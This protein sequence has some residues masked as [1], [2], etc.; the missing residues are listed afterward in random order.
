MW[1][2]KSIRNVAFLVHHFVV[3]II[4]ANNTQTIDYF[5][6][7]SVTR[8][9]IKDIKSPM[10]QTERKK[11]DQLVT[12]GLWLLFP[13]LEESFGLRRR[14]IMAV[15]TYRQKTVFFIFCKTLREEINDATDLSKPIWLNFYNIFTW[16]LNFKS[17]PSFID[18]WAFKFQGAAWE[19]QP[20]PSC[21]KILISNKVRED[22]N[23][24]FDVV[25]HKKE[26]TAVYERYLTYIKK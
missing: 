4:L 11:R 23:H 12:P 5:L 21:I 22:I 7:T 17:P 1:S 9:Q 18:C 26:T 19:Y 15:S 24:L 6:P 10:I 8:K 3:Y 16:P 14:L 2:L 13:A 25:L 20:W